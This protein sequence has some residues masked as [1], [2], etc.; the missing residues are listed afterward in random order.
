MKRQAIGALTP[1]RRS[2]KGDAVVT[3]LRLCRLLGSIVEEGRMTQT[4]L[5]AIL[6]S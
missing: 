2:P 5:H 3:H 6:P 4:D 1:A